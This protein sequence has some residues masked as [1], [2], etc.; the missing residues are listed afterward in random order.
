MYGG[1]PTTV[2]DGS[3]ASPAQAALIS[4][5]L[6]EGYQRTY[7][8]LDALAC[9]NRWLEHEPDNPQALFLR[10]NVYYPAKDDG[11]NAPFNKR[12]AK[13]G[14]VS[15]IFMAHGNHSPADPSYLGYDYERTDSGKT[16][17]C[18]DLRVLPRSKRP[19]RY[20]V[21]DDQGR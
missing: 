9:L 1:G 15:L 8:I 13:R 18:K 6:A 2:P 3:A 14:R 4:E 19:R 10:G 7:R 16:Y 11:A 17:S 20:D 5:A 12:R 21:C